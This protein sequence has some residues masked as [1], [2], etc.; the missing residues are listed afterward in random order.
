M[1]ATP[2]RPKDPRKPILLLGIVLLMASA[3]SYAVETLRLL[4]PWFLLAGAVLVLLYFVLR[5]VAATPATKRGESTMF[6][7]STQLGDP[8]DRRR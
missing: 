2:P 4:S 5:K 3:A 6:K 1:S 8:D 7:D